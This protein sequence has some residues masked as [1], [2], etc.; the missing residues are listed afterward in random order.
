MRRDI[1]Y[2]V[3]AVA[4]VVASACGKSDSRSGGDRRATGRAAGVTN[5]G[6]A[7]GTTQADQDRNRG[8]ATTG[9]TGSVSSGDEP[10]AG[11][12]ATITMKI[13]ARYAGDDVVRGRNIDVDTENGVVTLK[14]SVDSR[15]ERDAAEQIARETAGVKRVID[16][17]KVVTPR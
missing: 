2:A 16:E 12:D 3:L 13:Q 15:R 11:P 14:G 17:L 6:K 8:A 10:D 5:D 1:G 4:L 7:T 9:T